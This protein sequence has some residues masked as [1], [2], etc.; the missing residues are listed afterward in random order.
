MNEISR[1]RC[2][3]TTYNLT[4]KYNSTDKKRQYEDMDLHPDQFQVK[5]R[6]SAV[7]RR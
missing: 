5:A 4:K 2:I 7:R 3:A 6:K 1:T